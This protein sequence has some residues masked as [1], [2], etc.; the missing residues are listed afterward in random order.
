MP[1]QPSMKTDCLPLDAQSVQRAVQL[2]MQGELVAFPTETVYGLGA[3]ATQAA[4]VRK[5]FEAKGRPADHPLIVHI[6]DGDDPLRWAADWSELAQHLAD[7]F[8]P[9]P[10]TLIVP[11]REGVSD[12]LTGGQNTVGLRCPGHAGAQALLQ[13]LR[14]AGGGAVAAPSAN[15]FGRISPTLAS[16]VMEELGGRIPLILDGGDANVGIESTIIDVSRGYPVLLRPGDL[17]AKAIETVL[18]QRVARPDAQAPRV[19]GSLDSHYA[20]QRTL[21]QVPAAAMADVLHSLSLTGALPVAVLGWSEAVVQAAAA[22]G[23]QPVPRTALGQPLPLGSGA[24]D[25]DVLGGIG[26]GLYMPLSSDVHALAHDL[27]AALRWADH[28]PVRA[29]LVEQPPASPDWEGVADRLRR[30]SAGFEGSHLK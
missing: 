1:D 11:R 22:N 24:G 29:I 20:P 8:W 9:G 28:Q 7:T 30:A 19:S 6:A 4:A 15:R 2:L 14:Q 27:Y 18:G 16:H 26:A 21:R 12:L 13:A 25:G 5:I 17:S 10:L 23:L 3:D